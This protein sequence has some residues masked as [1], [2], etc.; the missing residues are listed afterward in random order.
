MSPVLSSAAQLTLL[1]LRLAGIFMM[2]RLTTTMFTTTGLI[3]TPVISLIGV[4]LIVNV[5]LVIVVCIVTLMSGDMARTPNKAPS[6]T[7][8]ALSSTTAAKKKI[9][10]NK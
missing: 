6:N 3:L 2:N 8:G 4:P 9:I 5:I 7:G 10:K 1:P